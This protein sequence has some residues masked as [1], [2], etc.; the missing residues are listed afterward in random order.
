LKRLGSLFKE[1]EKYSVEPEKS[2]FVLRERLNTIDNSIK[3]IEEICDLPSTM[4]EL[5]AGLSLKV[6]EA[7]R[8][9]KTVVASGLAR[10]LGKRDLNLSGNFPQLSCGLL[11]LE[12]TFDSGGKVNLYFG[13]RIEKLRQVPVHIESIAEAIFSTYD[14]LEGSG[15]DEESH[16]DAVFRAYNHTLHLIG[17]DMGSAVPLSDVMLQTAILKQSKKFLAD[18]VKSSFSSYGRSQF[19]YDL[20]R[21][22]IRTIAGHELHLTVASMEQTKKP[23]SHLWIPHGP[24]SLK[25][26]HFSMISFRE[27]SK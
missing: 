15:F 25:G 3:E 8:R 10:E 17:E 26:T 20:S 5:T 19:S 21:T 13:P 7:F 4:R 9:A 6:D 27:K 2:A 18:P 23:G 1:I 22:S 14:S 12:F 24:R 16:L 11:T